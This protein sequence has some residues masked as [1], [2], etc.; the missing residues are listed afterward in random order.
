MPKFYDLITP[1]GFKGSASELSGSCGSDKAWFDFIP[2][3]F[4]GVDISLACKIHDYMYVIGGTEKDKIKADKTFKKNL[5][6][7]VLNNGDLAW[8]DTNLALVNA[9]YLAV[10]RFGDSSFNYKNNKI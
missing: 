8:R 4:V 10:S 3:N 2:D 9:Y 1:D 5:T 7:L 6:A